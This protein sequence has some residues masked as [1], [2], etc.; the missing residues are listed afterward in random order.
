MNTTVLGFLGAGIA[1]AAYVPQIWHLVAERCAAGIS[2]PA[3]AAWLV[4]SVLVL[5]HAL[6]LGA[7]VFVTLSVF[8]ILAIG[9]IIASA[10]RLRGA[11]C[12]THA[13]GA[14]Q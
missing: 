2:V 4:A 14:Q 7:A 5:I 11:R 12:A 1:A 3:F 13:C 6:A 10:V 9:V 8:Q